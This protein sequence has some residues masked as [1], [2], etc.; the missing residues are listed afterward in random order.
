MTFFRDAAF[1]SPVYLRF[2]GVRLCPAQVSAERAKNLPYFVGFF[3]L[4]P[5]SHEVFW[6]DIRP[7]I[8]R[9]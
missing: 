5:F 2:L 8:G 9:K 3:S 1:F 6:S 4:P 7:S